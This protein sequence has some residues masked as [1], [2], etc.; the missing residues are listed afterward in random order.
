MQPTNFPTV[1][2]RRQVLGAQNGA[3]LQR[4]QDI[5]A[6]RQVLPLEEK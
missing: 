2:V 5:N 4:W 6:L 3:N 1:I